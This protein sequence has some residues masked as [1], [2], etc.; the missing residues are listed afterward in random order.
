MIYLQDRYALDGRD[1]NTYPNLY[2]CCGLPDRPWAERI[3][4][5]A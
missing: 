2:W 4:Q 1:P 5:M 3:R